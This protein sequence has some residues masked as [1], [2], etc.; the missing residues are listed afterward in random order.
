MSAA[1]QTLA[2][3]ESKTS[4]DDK[5]RKNPPQPTTAIRFDP[6]EFTIR[7]RL[8]PHWPKRNCDVFV[9]NKTDVRA[10]KKRCATRS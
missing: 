8:A 3:S 9:S 6:A 2:H 4:P 5:Q 10:Q 7:K 1:A